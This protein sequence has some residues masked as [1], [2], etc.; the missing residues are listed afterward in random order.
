MSALKGNK[1]YDISE[2]QRALETHKIDLQL[3]KKLLEFIALSI[4]Y[5]KNFIPAISIMIAREFA[6]E[7]EDTLGIKIDI[8][9]L[10]A[11]TQ[12]ECKKDKNNY[13]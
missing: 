12:V 8:D 5:S 1:E 7:I 11:R 9:E 13:I 6:F 2:A 3:R 10:V 4:I